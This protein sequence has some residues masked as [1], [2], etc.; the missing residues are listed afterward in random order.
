MQQR[1][2]ACY[3]EAVRTWEASD[4]LD[5][6]PAE[7]AISTQSLPVHLLDCPTTDLQSLGQFPLAHSL[8]ALHLDVL[9][10]LLGQ[11]GLP[12]R[13][14]PLGPRLRLARE[15]AIPGFATTR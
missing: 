5:M 8:R 9:S 4:R 11:T 2:G 7:A 6:L 13:E 14:A 3:D 12:A 15:R 1:D 10:L